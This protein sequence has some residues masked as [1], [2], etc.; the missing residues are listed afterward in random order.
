M[1]LAYVSS[2]LGHATVAVTAEHYARAVG[3]EYRAPMPLLEG[4]VPPDVTSRVAEELH[5]F[6]TSRPS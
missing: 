1:Q 4:E 2:W 5:E 3:D 6:P